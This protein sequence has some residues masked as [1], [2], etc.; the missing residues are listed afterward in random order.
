M[1]G[2]KRMILDLLT[3]LNEIV[4]SVGEVESF[5]DADKNVL[6]LEDSK[7]IEDRHDY[8][9]WSIPSIFGPSDAVR[10]IRRG[11]LVFFSHHDC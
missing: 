7:D 5:F 6:E 2:K 1:I 8:F 11:R 3:E 9:E 4:E 10:Y